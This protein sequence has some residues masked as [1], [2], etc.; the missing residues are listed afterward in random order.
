MMRTL[1]ILSTMSLALVLPAAADIQTEIP[2][3]RV[4]LYSSG[5]GYFECTGQVQDDAT[6]RLMFRAEQI[7]DVLKSMIV[8]DLGGGSVPAVHYASKEPLLRA[9]KSFAVDLSGP[10]DMAS[11]LGQ[12]RGAEATILAPDKV[13]GR[14]LTVEVR[15]VF[16]DGAAVNEPVISLMTAGGIRTYPLSAVQS[17]SLSDERLN[18]ELNKALTVLMASHD[19]Q[20]KAVDITFAGKGTRQVRIG[21]VAEAPVWKTT[22]R[23][24]LSGEKPLLQG[25]G[26]VENTTDS[27][28]TNVKLSLVTG[29]P[30]SFAMNLYDP[31]FVQRPLVQP[32]LYASLRPQE[33]EEG[34][35]AAKDS[36]RA[37][38][39]QMYAAKGMAPAPAAMAAPM[40]ERSEEAAAGGI[41]LADSVQS[42]AA[43]R[44]MGEVFQFAIA[45][46]V[47]L[48]RRQSAMLPIV[49]SPVACEKL[50]IYNPSVQAQHPLCGAYLSNDTALKLPAGP[51]TVY[52]NGAYAG[53]ARIGNFVP[54]DRRLISYALDLDVTVD[55][56]NRTSEQIVAAKIVRGMLEIQRKNVYLTTYTIKNKADQPR[57]ILVEHPYV[58]ERKLVEPEKYEEK[59]DD[60]YRLRISVDKDSTKDFP[61]RQEQITG[62]TIAVLG[63]P[64]DSLA[65]FA[66]SGQISPKVREAL[67]GVIAARN[68]LAQLQGQLDAQNV[69][70]TSL[71][72][73]QSRLTQNLDRVG[74]DSD[75]GRRYVNK[76]SQQEDQI[77]SIQNQQSQLREQIQK[78][79]AELEESLKNLNID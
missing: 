62:E 11:L 33:Y 56:S 12:L 3:T 32:E 60:M 44:Q 38:L 23:L 59:T 64:T 41:S 78:K 15:N 45:E 47:N 25:W 76:L 79:T 52:D 70:L 17:L 39:R 43:A 18:E 40:A 57:T 53:D 68:E 73:D 20:R 69:R 77:E 9:L 2:V 7:N 36:N 5:V 27:D 58:P 10:G 1:A 28:W 72:E 21:Y 75:L 71:R 26:I 8:Q 42:V 16:H 22:Y 74:R 24:E 14:I 6:A 35:G 63:C 65:W 19:T 66:K 50:S 54:G 31:L 67:A 46:S 29:R 4:V 48:P 37:V 51:I 49:N 55:S 13:A 30:I 34:V 61:V